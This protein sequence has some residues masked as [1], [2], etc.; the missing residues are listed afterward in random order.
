MEFVSVTEESSHASWWLGL[1]PKG[2]STNTPSGTNVQ[3][4]TDARESWI[5]LLPDRPRVNASKESL[6]T[7]LVLSRRYGLAESSTSTANVPCRVYRGGRFIVVAGQTIVDIRDS[8]TFNLAVEIFEDYAYKLLNYT[9]R[10]DSLPLTAPVIKCGPLL[11][12]TSGNQDHSRLRK[13]QIRSVVNTRFSFWFELDTPVA[14][15]DAHCVEESADAISLEKCVVEEGV[16][17]KFT[18][19]PARQGHHVIEVCAEFTDTETLVSTSQ[20]VETEVF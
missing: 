3:S 17:V 19:A 1:G 15:A 18:F 11:S 20:M 8:K 2:S 12:L 4:H 6:T 9:V 13:I 5:W 7:L 16:R 14:V 10:R